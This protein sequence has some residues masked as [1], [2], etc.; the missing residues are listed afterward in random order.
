MVQVPS[1]SID[2]QVFPP[3]SRRLSKA[4]LRDVVGLALD[5]RDEE[6][7]LCISLVIADDETVHGLNRDYR[8]LDEPTD[9]LAFPLW[10]SRLGEDDDAPVGNGSIDGLPP[11]ASAPV[12]EVVIS[13]P[14]AAKQARESRKLVRAEMALL[15]V[16]GVLHLIGYDH[17]DDCEKQRMWAV[18]DNVLARVNM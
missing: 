14:Q 7:P 10:E 13:Y 15:V 8:G 16:H 12:G 4:W 9:V 17:A 18:Q 3:Y 5:V 11:D 1:R 6:S 2:V